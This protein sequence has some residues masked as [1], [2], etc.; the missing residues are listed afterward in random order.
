MVRMS[1]RCTCGRGRQRG[2]AVGAARATHLQGGLSAAMPAPPTAP[3]RAVPTILPQHRSCGSQER[4]TGRRLRPCTAA[5]R[6]G[7]SG[8]A[9][10]GQLLVA[11]LDKRSP[12]PHPPLPCLLARALAVGAVASSTPQ[13]PPAIRR[14]V[15][16]ASRQLRG[17]GAQREVSGGRAG[18]CPQRGPLLVGTGAS[19][20]VCSAHGSGKSLLGRPRSGWGHGG[21]AHSA[22]SCRQRRRPAPSPS[23]PRTW[24]RRRVGGRVG[25]AGVARAF[26]C[27][28]R[29]GCRRQQ[30]NAPPAPGSLEAFAA[31][32]LGALA[33][34]QLARETTAVEQHQRLVFAAGAGAVVAALD[35]IGLALL[36]A[37]GGGRQGAIA[38]MLSGA[39]KG[40]GGNDSS[41]GMEGR[42]RQAGATAWRASA[43]KARTT[44]HRRRPSRG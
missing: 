16:A 13:A 15:L 23:H 34:S 25:R 6:G 1:S 10:S 29:P 17:V 35:A 28:H 27:E 5:G 43:E 31:L 11:A 42:G 9:G 22:W 24:G 30:A 18:S 33:Q 7:G 36:A 19:T 3:F 44:A 12:L 2:G 41:G 37:Q 20:P 21:S 4:G 8:S 26:G 14:H 38:R 39:C 40:P 32:A